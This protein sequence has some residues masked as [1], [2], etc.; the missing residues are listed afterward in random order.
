MGEGSQQVIQWSATR[1]CQWLASIDLAD[2]MHTL[3]NQGVHGAFMVGYQC[4]TFE[5]GAIFECFLDARCKIY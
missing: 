1:V 2:Y 3:T 5:G 4:P